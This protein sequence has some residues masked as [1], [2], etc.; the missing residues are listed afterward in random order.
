MFNPR[1]STP[2]YLLPLTVAFAILISIVGCDTGRNDT[3]QTPSDSA[4]TERAMEDSRPDNRD[5]SAG[6]ERRAADRDQRQGA[7]TSG[8]YATDSQ[9]QSAVAQIRPTSAGNAAGTVTFTTGDHDR[10]MR[11]TVELT[12]LKPGRHGFHIHEFGDCSADDASSAGGHFNPRDTDHGSPGAGEHHAGDMGNIE[13]DD[14][15]RVSSE[16]SFRGLVFSGRGSIL[17]RAVVVHRDADDLETQPAGD[18]GDPVGCGIIRSA[19][20]IS[21]TPAP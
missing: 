10:E 4:S 12:G 5:G 8:D 16:L 15:G 17:E 11:V 19:R 21:S 9:V 18:S 3:T 20:Q 6:N 14:N 13:A 2:G 7:A 1:A